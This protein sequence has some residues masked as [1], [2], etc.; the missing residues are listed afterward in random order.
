MQYTPWYNSWTLG[1]L[2][3]A[4]PQLS[5]KDFYMYVYRTTDA[6]LPALVTIDDEVFEEVDHL[7]IINEFV[8]KTRDILLVKVRHHYTYLIEQGYTC[9]YV[10]FLDIYDDCIALNKMQANMKTSIKSDINYF[11]LN[12]RSTR[13][14]SYMVE[15]LHSNDLIKNGYV[16]WH[17][18]NN[19]VKKN[20]PG[21][22]LDADLSHY[23]KR[24]AGFERNNHTVNGVACSSNVVNY[25]YIADNIPGMINISVET[26]VT[27]FFPTEKSFLWLYTKRL[28]ILIAEPGM[29]ELLRQQG[30]DVFD[31]I[32]D[33]GYDSIAK[34][35]PKIDA[36]IE[37][38]KLLLQTGITQDVSQRLEKNYQHATDTWITQQLDKLKADITALLR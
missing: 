10:P 17:D 35:R 25:F 11:C 2:K 14:R 28:P 16:T 36:A 33:H 8:D 29:I 18:A 20:L 9:L 24:A 15:T 21:L 30:F 4:F 22:R 19:L 6:K 31:D 37:S 7:D 26:W 38:N 3:A 32:I 12:R 1:Y 34:F 23:T 5:L 27:P 13:A